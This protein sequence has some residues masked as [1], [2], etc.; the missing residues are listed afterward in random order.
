MNKAQERDLDADATIKMDGHDEAQLAAAIAFVTADPGAPERARP[1]L[2]AVLRMM[3]PPAP[4][5]DDRAAAS[6]ATDLIV[7]PPGGRPW[8][9]PSIEALALVVRA[10]LDR[11]WLRCRH[12]ASALGRQTTRTLGAVA[13]LG[14]RLARRGGAERLRVLKTTMSESEIARLNAIA[15]SSGFSVS[16]IIRNLVVQEYEKLFDGAGPLGGRVARDADGHGAT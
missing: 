16:V 2:D 6:G 1:E 3:T 12:A 5:A 4:A 10:S 14:R 9:A 7:T 15:R 13:S 11:L 8:R